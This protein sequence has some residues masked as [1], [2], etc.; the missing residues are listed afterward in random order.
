M[1]G[2]KSPANRNVATGQIKGMAPESMTGFPVLKSIITG[3]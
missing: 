3:G 2:T 1:A